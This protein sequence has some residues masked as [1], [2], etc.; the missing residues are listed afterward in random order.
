MFVLIAAMLVCCAP[1]LRH[2]LT[3][4]QGIVDIAFGVGRAQSGCSY[5]IVTTD[6]IEAA[7][8]CRQ[9]SPRTHYK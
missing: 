7:E 1:V 6:T 5:I 4:V 3:G 9:A 8:Q 2:R